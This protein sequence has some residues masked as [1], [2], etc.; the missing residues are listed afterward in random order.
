MLA[1]PIS[2]L[3]L[4]LRVLVQQRYDGRV[5]IAFHPASAMLVKAGVPA[6]LA[7]RLET[8]QRILVD[9]IKA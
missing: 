2:A 6:E 1:A 9:A 3:D 4:P 7:G 8:A 5:I